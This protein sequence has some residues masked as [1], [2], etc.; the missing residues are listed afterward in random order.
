LFE[1]FVNENADTLMDEDV[2]NHLEAALQSPSFN[3]QRS[4]SSVT[5]A[6]ESEEGK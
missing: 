6:P 4:V 2:C 1:D 3:Q 5:T